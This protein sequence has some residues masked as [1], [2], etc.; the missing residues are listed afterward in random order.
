S[1]WA[2]ETPVDVTNGIDARLIEAE[3]AF[4]SGNYGTATTGTLAILN[5]LRGSAQTIGTVTTP[6]MAA[7][8]DPGTDS[9]RV[10]QLFR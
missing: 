10:S 3:A 9:A 7:L 2:Q 1:I 8:A 6:V 5:A 4:Q